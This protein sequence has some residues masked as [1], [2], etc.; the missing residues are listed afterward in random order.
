MNS[1]AVSAPGKLMLLGE[2]A[3][4][5][6]RPCL[7]TAVNQRLKLEIT[8]MEEPLLRLDAPDVGINDYRKSLNDL[9]KGHIPK[10]A[11]FVEIAVLNFFRKHR[12]STGMHVKTYTEFSSMFGFGSSSAATVC[13]IKALSELFNITLT[14]KELFDLAYKTV[15]DIQGKGSGFDIAA[16]IYGGTLYFF[17]AGKKIEPLKIKSLPLIVGYSGVKADTVTLINQIKEKAKKYPDIIDRIY[18]HIAELVEQAKQALLAK[19]WVRFGELMNMNQGYLNSLG[20]STEKLEIM[21][22]ATRSAGAYGAKLSG[23]GGGDCMIAIAPENKKQAVRDAITKKGGQIIDTT[24]NCK[25]VI[26]EKYD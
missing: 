8:I 1:I 25:G 9:G 3:V 22:Y 5:Y 20:V 19:D 11:K 15:L 2:Y 4:V 21:I 12:R 16:A 10:G 6:N 18:D 24:T 14:D 26:I 13:T 23:A 17:T 7:V